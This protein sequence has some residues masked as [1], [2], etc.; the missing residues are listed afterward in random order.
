VLEAFVG[1]TP[2]VLAE[3]FTPDGHVAA[4]VDCADPKRIGD[5]LREAFPEVHLNIDHHISNPGYGTHNFIEDGTSATAEILAAFFLDQGLPLDA[6]TAQ[7]LYV[8]IATDTGQF[9]FPSTTAR[10][11][12]LAA[13]LLEH[14]AHAGDAAMELFEKERFAKLKLMERFLNSLRLEFDGRVCIGCL[15]DGIY[16]ATGSDREDAEGL[17]DYARAI[18]GVEIGVLLEE[19]NGS[20]K[21][22][23]RAK[24]GKHRV[25]Q[26]AGDFNG[27]GHA[28]AAG[29]NLDGSIETVY[30][31]LVAAIGER[32]GATPRS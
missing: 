14:G 3:A 12:E 27:G 23:L 29:F 13:A 16:Q 21:G 2:F 26:I 20:I 24:D 4:T 22:S 9:R 7:A 28:A 15:E 11:F 32:L 5:R 1:D 18:D 8:G 31:R 25:D 6:T 17:V 19:T 30:P 10:V